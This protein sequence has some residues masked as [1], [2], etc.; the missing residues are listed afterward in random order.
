MTNY[1]LLRETLQYIEE[2]PDEH[3]QNV[4]G[5]VKTACKTK[6]CFAG[7]ALVLGGAEISWGEEID[8]VRNEETGKW[9]RIPYQVMTGATLPGENEELEP[10]DAGQAIL[11]LTR[12]QASTIF[13]NRSTIRGVRT[14]VKKILDKEPTE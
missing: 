13:L 4:Y 3:D 2:H 12:G 14:Q 9:D 5:Q 8:Y 1:P 6:F 10:F 7:H 11:G